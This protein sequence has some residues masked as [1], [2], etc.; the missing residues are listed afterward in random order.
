VNVV[1]DN[2]VESVDSAFSWLHSL[3]ETDAHFRPSPDRWTIS[4][5][6]GHLIDSA[7]NN[8]QRFIRAQQADPYQGPKY[9][10]NFWV[11]SQAYDQRDWNEL[12]EFW[13]SYNYQLAHLM[14]KIPAEKLATKCFVETY[15]PCTLEFLLTDYVDHMDHHLT[16]IRERVDAGQATVD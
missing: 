6:I 10:Q 3:N 9:D 2:L 7:A 4:E 11:S 5:V 12:L 8:H 1:A 14:R 15:E 16:K 13:R